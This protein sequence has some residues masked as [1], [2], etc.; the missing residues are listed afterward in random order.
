MTSSADLLLH[1]VRLRIVQALLGERR[2]TTADLA[3]ELADVKPATLYRHVAALL[4]GDVLRVAEE[5]R[6]RG[7]TERTYALRTE[8]ASVDPNDLADLD[9]EAHRRMFATFVAML[10]ADFDRYLAT[11]DPVDLLADGVGYRQAALWLRDD[12]VAELGAALG[13]VL[14]RYVE[15]GPGDG[16]RRRLLTTVLVPGDAA[17]PE[18]PSGGPAA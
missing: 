5:R 13:S 9:A 3:D 17:A 2:L 7:A 15:A 6:V 1:P 18:P 11:A 4:D 8:A 10:L 16:R 12:E 14:A